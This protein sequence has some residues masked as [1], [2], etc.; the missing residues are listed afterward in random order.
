MRI[1]ILYKIIIVLV[2]SI[3]ITGISIFFTSRHLM[4]EGFEKET[5]QQLHKLD[6][7]V[8]HEFGQLKQVYLNS[9][10]LIVTNTELIDAIVKKD[11]ET[12]K[13]ILINDMNRIDA[14][15][16]VLTD[17]KGNVI[18]RAHNKKKEIIL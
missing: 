5:S 14:Q 1:S 6:K 10:R 15:F 4:S 3:M 8:D 12:I 2:C 18:L 11:I 13:K 17:T 16:A 9:S 7:I